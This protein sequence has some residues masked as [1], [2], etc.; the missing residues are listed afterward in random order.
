MMSGWP[1][2]SFGWKE[3]GDREGSAEAVAVAV[4]VWKG[5]VALWMPATT[6]KCDGEATGL[7]RQTNDKRTNI[8]FAVAVASAKERALYLPAL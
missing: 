3:E 1:S 5:L 4:T 6:G 7:Q 2:L 8:L